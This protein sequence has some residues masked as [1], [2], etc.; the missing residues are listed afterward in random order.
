MTRP[1]PPQDWQ[2]RSMVKKPWLAR[3]LPLPPQVGQAEGRVPTF[4]PEPL[5]VSQA[6]IA[7]TRIEAD[8]PRKASSRLISRL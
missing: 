2:V 4:A 1:A 5:Q 7:W 8:L 3:T 6:T